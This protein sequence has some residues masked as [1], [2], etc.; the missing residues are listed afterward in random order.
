MT[1]MKWLFINLSHKK[2]HYRRPKKLFPESTQFYVLYQHKF[3]KSK[4][5]LLF[6]RLYQRNGTK[7]GNKIFQYYDQYYQRLIRDA[8]S[9]IIL[10]YFFIKHTTSIPV[11]RNTAGDNK[12]EQLEMEDTGCV[13]G[14]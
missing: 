13:S 9:H 4:N 8:L 5:C 2:T 14:T 6:V 10:H 3:F 12:L 11:C 7:R 1:R